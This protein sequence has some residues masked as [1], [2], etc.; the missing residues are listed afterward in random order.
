MCAYLPLFSSLVAIALNAIESDGLSPGHNVEVPLLSCSAVVLHWSLY[1]REEE[2]R[3][4]LLS[5]VAILTRVR[6]PYRGAQPGRCTCT[7]KD[8]ISWY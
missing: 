3:I 5:L 6:T 4:V 7:K 8:P 2:P 1:L